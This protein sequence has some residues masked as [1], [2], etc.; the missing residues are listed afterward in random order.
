M[1]GYD[2]S[3]VLAGF[4]GSP[5]SV[6]A[7][8]WAAGEARLRRLPLAVCH[9]WHWPYP[10]P[11]SGSAILEDFRRTAQHIVDKGVLIARE[12]APRT[13]VRGRLRA[14]P[15]SAVLVNESRNA[16]L[17][18]VGAHGHGGFPG[19]TTGSSAARLPAYAHSPVIVVRNADEPRG[20]IV[21]G[22]DGSAG[23]EAALAFGFEEAALRRRPL[24]AVYGCEEPDDATPTEP[25]TLTDADEA[26]M[27]A[28]SRLER[29]TSPWREK[30]PYVDAETSLLS[31]PPQD[32]LLKAAT[33]AGLLVVGGRG[34]GGAEGFRLGAVS[35]GMLQH[36]PCAVAVVRPHA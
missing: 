34:L 28:C 5:G 24:R 27:V 32:A 23:S 11:P 20:P 4:D 10:V 29:T 22:V 19:L 25:G 9:A 8:R 15:T 26:R 36:A 12:A 7:L 2:G 31:R 18:V 21:V 6:L 33:G 13:V 3:C 35:S 14:G 16:A 17:V 1:G 30:Y